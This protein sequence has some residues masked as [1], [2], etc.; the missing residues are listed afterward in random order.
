MPT[1]LH[2][3]AVLRDLAKEVAEIS[4]MPVM[5]SRRKEWKRHNALKRGRPMILI[6]PEGAWCE[7]LPDS[8]LE[9]R[10]AEAR[11]IEWELRR[12]IYVYRH[13]ESDNVVEREWVVPKAIRLTSWGLEPRHRDSTTARGAWAF[14]PVIHTPADLKKLRF[15]EVIHD[16]AETQ[17]RMALAQ[18]LFGDIL[19]V[20]LKGVAHISFHLMHHYTAL[21][22]LEQVMVDMRLNPGMLHDAMAFLAEGNRRIVQQYYEQN[23]LSLNNDNT[24]H[25][26]G[27]VGYTD[28]LPAPGFDPEHVRPCDMWASAES[29]EMAQVSP[30]MHREFALQYEVK[31]LEPFGLNGYGCCEDLS[32]KLE[33]VLTIPRIRRISIAPSADVDI[34][35]HKLGNRAIFSWKPDPTFLLDDVRRDTLEPYIRH[36]L[37]AARDCTLEMI[38]KDTH[39]CGG[40]P[41]RFD[42]WSRIARSLVESD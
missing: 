34:C 2:D 32:Q 18:D 40:R 25:S 27:G 5:E 22:G 23:L 29:Q 20:K 11:S 8:V 4:S 9:C 24:Y 42:E 30:K 10:D 39:T 1:D 26:S 3:R 7:L 16:E 37:E 6:F 28:E 21:R 38:L 14:D 35:A 13:F 36:T 33:D 41:E 12:R 31:L 19:E 17:R 15:P